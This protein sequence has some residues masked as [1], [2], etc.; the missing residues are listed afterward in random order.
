MRKIFLLI[1]ML[2][3]IAGLAQFAPKQL[4]RTGDQPVLRPAYMIGDIIPGQA[5]PNATVSPKS[6]ME[7]PVI[8]TTYYDLQ[9]NA[10]CQN[11]I[12]LYPDGT[13]GTVFTMAHQ[14]TFAD[15]G[16]GYNYFNETAWGAQPTDRLE[17]VRTGWPS[18]APYG[19]AGEIVASH[20]FYNYPMRILTRT[21]KGSGTWNETTLEIPSGATGID[22]PRMVTGGPDHMNIHVIA[23]TPP[24]ANQGV[25]YEGLDGAL[26]YNR[27]LDGGTT[28][29]G[30]QILDGMTSSD[31]LGFTADA[32]AWAEPRGDTLCFV[33]GNNWYDQFIMK[34]TDNGD[35]WTKTVIWPCPYNF[36]AGGD[37][38]G[39]FYCPD[40]VSAVA[41][42]E[43]GKAHVLFGL[44][45]AMGDES[46]AKYWYP[47]TDGLI[48]WNEDKPELPDVLDPVWLEENGYVI[49]WVQDTMVWYA[50]E[51]QLAFYYNSMSS[52]PQLTFSHQAD[53]EYLHAV[54]SSVTTLTDPDMFLLRHIFTRVSNDN[55]TTWLGIYDV[56]DDFLY[57]WSECVY[58]S[59]SQHTDCWL[60][61]LFQQDDLA[62]AYVQTPTQGQGVVTNN[63]MTYLK[64]YVCEVG[65]HENTAN[66]TGMIVAPAFPNPATDQA[67]IRINLSEP[68][69]ITIE[70]ASALGKTIKV[71]GLGQLPEGNHSIVLDLSEYANGVYYYS[72]I[73]DGA[74]VSGKLVKE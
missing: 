71:M 48:Y 62:G 29:S 2:P 18:Y 4:S 69:S 11:R 6:T 49:G 74:R 67:T 27:S 43:S 31:Y 45:R 16:T 36:W 30:W 59:V 65:I 28:W 58:P 37:T 51:T 3:A 21:T 47:W 55:G 73:T 7:D 22:W 1:F 23:L 33:V 57:T 64:H 39:I 56:T 8:G 17:S 35:T 61:I 34:S 44:Q 54:W 70:L 52:M 63:N 72:V 40:G 42:D 38:T 10:S 41:L 46:G 14:Q 25:V 12:Y 68:A 66:N 53:Y 26:V 5:N 50:D 19:P 13:I 15:R 32:Y 9:T 60:H 20:Q 24:T